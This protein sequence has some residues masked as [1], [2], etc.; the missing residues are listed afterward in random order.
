MNLHLVNFICKLLISCVDLNV[1]VL[2][3]SCVNLMYV[4]S[5]VFIIFETKLYYTYI[6]KVYDFY[7]AFK[8]RKQALRYLLPNYFKYYCIS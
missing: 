4:I 3:N 6:N 1:G 2:I 8:W 5:Y 7:E